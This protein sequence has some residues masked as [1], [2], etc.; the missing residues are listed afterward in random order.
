[1]R[2]PYATKNIIGVMQQVNSNWVSKIGFFLFFSLRLE[3]LRLIS[4]VHRLIVG[5]EQALVA[6]LGVAHLLQAIPVGL[7][8]LRR[9]LS[10]CGRHCQ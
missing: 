10:C 9:H 2:V 6:D 8:L 4:P 1:M 3:L 5:L 7:L